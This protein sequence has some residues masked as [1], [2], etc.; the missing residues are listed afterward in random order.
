MIR[1]IRTT[2][3][4]VV[5]IAI[6]G[7]GSGGSEGN[8]DVAGV[9]VAFD[10][11]NPGPD[12]PAMDTGGNDLDP[13]ADVE[14]V[15]LDLVDGDVATS[16]VELSV[17]ID[18]YEGVRIGYPEA[19][20][21]I[22][23]KTAQDRYNCFEL[24]PRKLPSSVTASQKGIPLGVPVARFQALPGL[25]EDISQQYTVVAV[26]EDDS[27][28]SRVLAWACND[29]DAKV[30]YGKEVTVSLTLFDVAP[31]IVGTWDITSSF[32][33]GADLPPVV[34]DVLGIVMGILVQ[35]SSNIL[36]L[37]CD[38]SIAGIGGTQDF[39]DL[40]FSDPQ[41]PAPG[42][43]TSYGQVAA[44]IIDSNYKAL[45][46][47]SCP[48]PQPEL[49]EQV[50]FTV[51]DLVPPLGQVRILSSMTCLSDP[52]S[53]HMIS[54]APRS[55]EPADCHED[56]HTL[57]LR[58]PIG[59][60]CDPSDP[61]CGTSYFSLRSL[62]GFSDDLSNGIYGSLGDGWHLNII[63][64][65][66]GLKKGSLISFVL[67]SF[68]LPRILGDGSDGLPAV[69]SIE[70]LVG[71]MFGGRSCL[72][73]ASCCDR[74]DS[75]LLVEMSRAPVGPSKA[76]CESLL[77]QFSYLFRDQMDGLDA[78]GGSQV[79]TAGDGALLTDLEGNHVFDMV[80]S[81]EE[82]GAWITT[83]MVG[84]VEYEGSASFYG[85]RM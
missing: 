54:D 28:G 21:I 42:A 36:M 8:P 60:D 44:S 13:V 59:Q 71:V 48:Y 68:I 74:F 53:P 46:V 67:L 2:F 63:P 82:P 80:G 16:L 23:R 12:V 72:M 56:W 62:P 70:K 26:V 4:L 7:C 77:D 41:D 5:A 84:A 22:Y 83:M 35:P 25:A 45:L 37:M 81:S 52:P 66:V 49:C 33:F 61:E 79:G 3:I 55:F 43:Y 40:V 32:D 75:A 18:D 1:N 78:Q 14:D 27:H 50:W 85:T 6:F 38:P 57:A 69:D 19:T 73:D 47:S 17:V 10:S 31:S 51:N 15:P 20:V 76:A 24:D 34:E 29:Q 58:W 39:C 65:Q 9:D 64:H 30:E 11:S